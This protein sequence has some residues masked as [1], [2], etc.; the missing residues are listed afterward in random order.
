MDA[1]KLLPGS[2]YQI[3]QRRIIARCPGHD[4]R[5]RAKRLPDR[6]DFVAVHL[7]GI[8]AHDTTGKDD[9]KQAHEDEQIAALSLTRTIQR[10]VTQVVSIGRDWRN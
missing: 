5:G 7:K 8:Q 10:Q 2:D 1:C 6:P 3:E 4:L 9:D